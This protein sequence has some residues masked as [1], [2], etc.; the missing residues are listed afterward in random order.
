MVAALS[1]HCRAAPSVARAS[2]CHVDLWS[3]D[4]GGI[5]V[6]MAYSNGL[7]QRTWPLPQASAGIRGNGLAGG[8]SASR[9][10]PWV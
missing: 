6:S 4:R 8:R 10:G 9:R 5:T 7:K 1:H 2:G 3:S